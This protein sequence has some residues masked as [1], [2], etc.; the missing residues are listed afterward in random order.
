MV[1]R[2]I[3]AAMP[4][5]GDGPASQC[6]YVLLPDLLYGSEPYEPMGRRAV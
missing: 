4:E 3:R 5:I 1:G 6:C 2:R